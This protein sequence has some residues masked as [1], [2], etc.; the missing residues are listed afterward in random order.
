[1]GVFAR[2]WAAETKARVGYPS[3][4]WPLPV[5]WHRAA[6]NG[7]V[8]NQDKADTVAAWFGGVRVIA[9]DVAKLPLIT[10]RRNGRAKVRAT[11]HP[12]YRLLH[13]APNPEMTSF[14]WRETAMGHLIN[15]GNCYAERELDDRGRTIAMWPLRPDRMEVR[16][17]DT[18]RTYVYTV[19]PGT[20]PV[21]LEPRRIFHIPGMGFDGLIGHSVL[22]MA[23]ETLSQ[24]LALREYSSRVLERDARPGVILTHPNTLSSV[25]RKN[26]R[27][28]W[29]AEHGGFTNAGRTAVLEEGITVTELGLPRDDLLFIQGQQWQV[30]EVARWLRLAPHKLADLTH[31]TFSN[32][33]EQSL[34]HVSSTLQAWLTRWEQQIDKDLLPEPG[35]FAEHLMDAALR[36]KTLDRYQAFAIAAQN[37]ALTPNEWREFENWNPVPW[38]DEPISTPNNSASPDAEETAA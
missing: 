30:T 4:G 24:A 11:D 21:E 10:Y 19:K 6:T 7:I 38:G 5:G 29:E 33:E 28:S 31:A 34:D 2:T 26:I 1:M 32:I 25:A 12:M 20:A 15:W 8:V 13:D 3:P 16:L 17:D 14:I 9:E 22:H 18:T 35:L 37:K 36:G 23:R 27:D